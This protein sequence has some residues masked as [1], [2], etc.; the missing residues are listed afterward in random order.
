LKNQKRKHGLSKFD[1]QSLNRRY[2]LWMYKMTKD[3]LDRIDRK[4]TQIDIDHT[5]AEY[6]FKLSGRLNKKS[7]DALS[8]FFREW[9]EYL[10]AKEGDAERLKW[11]GPGEL[12]ARYAFLH[13]KLQAILS[14]ACKY[15]GPGSVK[16][17]QRLYEEK[18]IANILADTSGRR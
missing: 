13:L 10:E 8:P 3:E 1:Y 7:R 5:I 9:D 6:F 16:E 15:L 14:A 18:A 11:V 17:F 12:E 2:L 4:Y